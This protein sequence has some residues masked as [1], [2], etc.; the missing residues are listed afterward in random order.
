MQRREAIL[1]GLC[2]LALA[3]GAGWILDP[4][5]RPQT[6]GVAPSGLA[7]GAGTTKQTPGAQGTPSL[8]PGTPPLPSSSPRAAP[9]SRREVAQ[10][11]SSR[12]PSPTLV[13]APA[14]IR[15]GDF[16]PP[17]DL[18][19]EVWLELRSPSGLLRV[20]LSELPELALSPGRYEAR[21]G[22]P[23]YLPTAAQVISLQGGASLSL[24][25]PSLRP[26][27]RLRGSVTAPP[28]VPLARVLLEVVAIAG[29]GLKE[30]SLVKCSQTGAF[31]RADL[32]EGR[33]R[34]RARI[35]AD[36]VAYMSSWTPAKASAEPGA[37]P[38]LRL[39]R[40]EP[41][42]AG[43]VFDPLGKAI[44]GVTLRIEF[45][46]A[47]SDEEGRYDL[48]G[49]EPGPWAVEA[50]AKGYL[51]LRRNVSL[52]AGL[53]LTLTPV[54]VVTGHILNAGGVSAA[55]VRVVLFQ[56]HGEGAR[57]SQ[58]GLSDSEGRFRFEPLLPGSYALGHDPTAEPLGPTF[59][60]EPGQ[61]REE[62]VRLLSGK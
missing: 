62:S 48:Y 53:D 6:S 32:P 15:L 19:G 22:A 9:S 7:T 57:T 21:F 28:G 14:R 12:V 20:P 58:S 47:R 60:L 46:E 25:P 13:R 23:G 35:E 29:S 30:R 10:P 33:Y 3:I 26:A 17:S 54:S 18:E 34:I 36:R 1:G 5:L 37:G 52:G 42:L 31:E 2:G 50:E 51:K 41:S 56:F 11:E 8:A 59:E 55:G 44:A 49:V 27:R 39:V 45:E 40:A 24:T 16:A 43:R 61:T 38:K 4:L